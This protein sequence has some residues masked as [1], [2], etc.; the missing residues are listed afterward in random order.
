MIPLYN[1]FPKE[2]T[3]CLNKVAASRDT[4]IIQ[5]L[6]SQSQISHDQQVMKSN[7]KYSLAY[8]KSDRNPERI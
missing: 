7:A 5:S 8:T 1:Q 2:N 4:N 6:L 3:R